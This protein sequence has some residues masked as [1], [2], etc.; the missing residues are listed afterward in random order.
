MKYYIYGTG[1]GAGDEYVVDETLEDAKQAAED[2]LA[3][4]QTD[5]KIQTE[6]G[7]DVAIL[8]WHGGAEPKDDDIVTIPG[9]FGDYGFYGD[10]LDL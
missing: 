8:K 9:M 4:T 7:K 5:V 1:A 10:W 2:E 3:Y 6:D